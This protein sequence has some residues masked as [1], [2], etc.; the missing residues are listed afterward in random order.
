MAKRDYY[1]SLGV[2]KNASDE[3]IK[4]AYRK[5][6]MKHHP[7]RNQGDA[8]KAAEV[9]FKECK[10]AYEMLSDGNKRAAYDQYGHAG[11]DPN[12]GG[13]AHGAEGFGGFAEAFGDIFGEA[14]G[15]GRGRQQGG[16]RQ[17]YRGGDLS[18]AME[19]TLEEAADGKERNCAVR[20]GGRGAALGAAGSAGGTHTGADQGNRSARAF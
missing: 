5:M 10:E 12:R 17:V 19:V 2:A 9:K 15:G 11:V 7:D 6:A 4:K 18:Y 20:G 8:A 14:F 16:G 3:D 1:E 13:G